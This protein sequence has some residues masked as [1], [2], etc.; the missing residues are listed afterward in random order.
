MHMC[1]NVTAYRRTLEISVSLQVKIKMCVRVF[2]SNNDNHRQEKCQ[3]K[4]TTDERK[5]KKNG[6]ERYW[7][8]N[9]DKSSCIDL[10][11][12]NR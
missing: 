6:I 2:M 9:L 11:T 8:L 5:R 10:F 7:I 3:Q 4:R 1:M 12:K